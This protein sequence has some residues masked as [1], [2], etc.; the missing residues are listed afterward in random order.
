VSIFELDIAGRNPALP[1]LL[2][3][4]VG[5]E[6]GHHLAGELASRNPASVTTKGTQRVL[7]LAVTPA[8]VLGQTRCEP[9]YRLGEIE[10][11]I[12]LDLLALDAI[13]RR[14]QPSGQ[15]TKSPPQ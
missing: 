14:Q 6:L 3:G 2:C 9:A 15:Y 8:R 7:P 4:L 12:G 1:G 5:V 11:G 10:I 13:Q